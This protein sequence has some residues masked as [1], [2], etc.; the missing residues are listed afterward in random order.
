MYWHFL[1]EDGCLQ[2]GPHTKVEVGQ[3]LTFDG[4]PILCKQGFHASERLI[5]ALDYSPGPVCCR[6]ELGGEIVKGN[7]KVVAQ[8]RTVLWMADISETLHHFACDVAEEALKAHQVTDERSWNAIHTKRLWLKGEASDGEL[9][10]ARG[11]AWAAARDAAWD[12]AWAAARDAQNTR[13]TEIV[14][15]LIHPEMM[16]EQE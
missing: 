13:L 4:P 10:A 1:R 2:F 16:E 9:A 15:A 12:V 7:D 3:T 14:T 6:V 8:T 5:D 11:A